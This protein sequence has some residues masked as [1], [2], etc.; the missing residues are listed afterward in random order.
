MVSRYKGPLLATRIGQAR[1]ELFD[2]AGAAL[3][4]A[5]WSRKGQSVIYAATS[6]SG[7]LLEILV[8]SNLGRVPRGFAYIQI[9]IQVEVE[10]EEI[11]PEDVPG[12]DA[13]DGRA[14]RAWGSR[15]Y[16]EQRTAVLLVPSVP[17]GGVER[18]VLI[19]Q[20]HPD[21]ARI[22]ASVPMPVMWDQRI[23]GR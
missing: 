2:G 12:W 15:W 17:S 21:F 3:H 10:M 19:H 16:E 5:R 8:H 1:H 7:A 18:N 23:F 6:F 9:Q 13:A 14:S 22:T 4:G 11:G 20:R